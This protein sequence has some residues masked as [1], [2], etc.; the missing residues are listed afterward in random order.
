MRRMVSKLLFFEVCLETYSSC[1][2]SLRS[3]SY[4]T[5]NARNDWTKPLRLLITPDPYPAW[6]LGLFTGGFSC[7]TSAMQDLGAASAVVLAPT[8]PPP[9]PSPTS[10]CPHTKSCPELALL[11]VQGLLTLSNGNG[12]P[13]FFQGEPWMMRA[14]KIEAAT[15]KYLKNRMR[16]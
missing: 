8:H 7:H 4:C 3:W 1:I 11:C 15:S 9:P 2:A 10:V 14:H 5:A 16:R 13:D 12:V 6:K